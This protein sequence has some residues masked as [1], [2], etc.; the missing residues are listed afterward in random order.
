MKKA[1]FA[2]LLALCCAGPAMAAD[3]P[4]AMAPTG[5]K[6]GDTAPDFSARASQGGKEFDFSLKDALR[7]GPAVVYFYPSAYTQGCDLEAHTFAE[8]REKFDAAGAT[9]IGVSGDS[10]QRLDQFSAD[11]A[12]CAGKFPVASDA[13]GK[14]SAAYKLNVAKRAGAKDVR[15]VAIDHDFTERFTYVIGRDGKILATYSSAADKVTPEGHVE[16][17]LALVEQIARK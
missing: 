5:L 16:K 7:K 2:G 15:G 13:D 3:A 8:N 6:T 1:L 9:I 17:S 14:I 10:I 4:A 11:P 12:Y